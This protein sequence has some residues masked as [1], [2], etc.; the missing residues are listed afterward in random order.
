MSDFALQIA[1][2]V[3]ADPLLCMIASLLHR[4][5]EGKTGEFRSNQANSILRECGVDAKSTNRINDIINHLLPQT[6]PLQKSLEEQVV[7]DA[8]ILTYW[9]NF[10]GYDEIKFNFEISDKIFQNI[11]K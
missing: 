6:Q 11:D 1:Q 8:Y 2:E 9:Q 10:S 3:G 5:A 7:A 4:W